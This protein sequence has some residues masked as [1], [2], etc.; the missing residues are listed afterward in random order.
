MCNYGFKKVYA[1]EA[2]KTAF[3]TIKKK[4]KNKNKVKLVNKDFNYF[5]Y[6]KTSF[7]L[8]L[9]RG[10]ITHNKI[11][12]INSILKKINYSLK[13]E[14]YFFS[15]MFSKRGK[16]KNIKKNSYTFKNV[17]NDKTGLLAN[18]FSKKEILKLFKNFKIIDLSEVKTI[19][20]LP[21]KNEFATWNIIC[22]K[23]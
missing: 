14:G 18:F 22:K 20:Y 7:D 5:N 23:K 21:K 16:F 11:S 15:V 4:F 13:K 17:T 9:D 3:D 19:N 12:N 8:I 2:S 1:V 10:S 6:K